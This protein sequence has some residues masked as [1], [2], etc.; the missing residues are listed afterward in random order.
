M[1]L[2]LCLTSHQQQGPMVMGPQL[3]KSIIRQTGEAKDRP[4]D[5]GLHGKWLIHYTTA[6]LPPALVVL[7]PPL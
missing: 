7:D 2:C 1:L 3:L 6:A 5:P 4:W